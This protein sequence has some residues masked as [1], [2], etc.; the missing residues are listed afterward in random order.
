MRVLDLVQI[1]RHWPMLLLGLAAL[2]PCIAQTY[3]DPTRPAA[4]WLAAQQAAT[5]NE[6]AADPLTPE[7]NIVMI[8]PVRS[9]VIVAGQAIR[10]GESLNGYKLIAVNRDRI[11][12]QRNGVGEKANMSPA[13]QKKTLIG[14]GR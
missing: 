8:G 14:E 3:A 6:P 2:A 5:G 4:K 13:V 9:F 10:P 1:L 7:A 11:V 12:W